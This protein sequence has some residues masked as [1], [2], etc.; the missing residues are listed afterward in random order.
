MHNVR[1]PKSFEDIRTVDGIIHGTFRETCLSLGLLEDDR[2]W[3]QT[4]E[5]AEACKLP[6][7]MRCLF[8]IMLM[9][10]EI[11]DTMGIWENIKKQ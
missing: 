5:E 1:G 7:Q 11:S 9:S 2:H 3:D 10:C 4:L 6:N 8:A